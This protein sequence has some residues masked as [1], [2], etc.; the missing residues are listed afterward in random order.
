MSALRDSLMMGAI[1]TL[2]N[3][4]ET[5]W[6]RVKCPVRRY[7]FMT[8]NAAEVWNARLVWA[9]KL[10]VCSFLEAARRIMEKWFVKRRQTADER[11]H[12]LTKNVHDKLIE[13]QRLGRQMDVSELG[14]NKFKVVSNGKLHVVD[15]DHRMCTCWE[16]QS[17]LIPCSHACAA[18][19]SVHFLIFDYNSLAHPIS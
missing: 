1:N 4:Q 9:R 11:D 13:R 16:F 8:S 5:R 18:I 15:L 2:Q 7:S 3:A 19:R 14:G 17:E 12:P 6:S 10:P